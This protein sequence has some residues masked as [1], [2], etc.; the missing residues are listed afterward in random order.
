MISHI[1]PASAMLKFWFM[2][3]IRVKRCSVS[4]AYSFYSLRPRYLSLSQCGIRRY[5]PMKNSSISFVGPRGVVPAS[6]ATFFAIE[7]DE[8]GIRKTTIVG[9]VFL[10]VIITV[11]L[12]GSMLKKNCSNTGGN[13]HGNIHYWRRK[14]RPDSCRRC[15]KGVKTYQLWNI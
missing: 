6:I 2:M 9:L 7:L 14:S 5:I 11:F 3:E 1:Y 8:M 15:L 10:T 13:S 12:T 4:S